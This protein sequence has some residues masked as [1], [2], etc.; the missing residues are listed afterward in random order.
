MNTHLTDKSVDVVTIISTLEHV[1]LG[2]YGDP[3]DVDGD[4]RTMREVWRILKPGG[5]AIL[6][7]PYGYPTVV[8][9]LHRVYDNGRLRLLTEGFKPVVVQYSSLGKLC[10]RDR[11]E[12][13]KVK[14]IGKKIERACL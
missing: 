11:I 2:R 9:N 12:G 1:G 6:T 4:I 14:I 13:K 7:I 5:H 8:Y 3:L 10:S